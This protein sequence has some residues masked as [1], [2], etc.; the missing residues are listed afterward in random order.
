MYEPYLAKGPGLLTRALLLIAFIA[1]E[2]PVLLPHRKYSRMKEVCLVVEVGMYG[3]RS[4]SHV[5]HQ[6]YHLG[7]QSTD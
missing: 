6:S 2:L 4:I 5:G 7:R 3:N 1:K